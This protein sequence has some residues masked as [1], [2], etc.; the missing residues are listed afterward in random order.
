MAIMG[1]DLTA[2]ERFV[3]DKDPAKGTPD[4]T[5]LILGTL[6][7]NILGHIQDKLTQ[8]EPTP[9]GESATAK[10]NVHE[11]AILAA[12]FALQGWENFKDTKANDIEFKTKKR[13]VGGKSYSIVDPDVIKIVPLDI[14]MEMYRQVRDG[15]TLK[16]EEAKNSETE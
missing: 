16:A 3:S 15:N 12:Q 6:D 1:L 5:I 9:D 13:Y 14:I 7:A 4:E 10:V 8:Y 2:T 11:A